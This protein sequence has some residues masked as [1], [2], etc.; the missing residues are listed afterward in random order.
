MAD[1]NQVGPAL[2]SWLAGATGVTGLLSSATA[3]YNG[4]APSGTALPYIVM[5]AVSPRELNLTSRRGL[6]VLWQVKAIA[7]TYAAALAIAY[8]VDTRLIQSAMTVTGWSQIWISRE[9]GIDY[10]EVD[11]DGQVYYHVG[12]TYRIRLSET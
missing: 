12:A 4:V 1:A 10:P 8:Q 9:T 7:K 11:D 5:D 6:D 2:Y 3:L